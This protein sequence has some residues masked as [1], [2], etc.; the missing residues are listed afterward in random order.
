MKLYWIQWAVTDQTYI[1][2]ESALKAI[3]T[4]DREE[5]TFSMEDKFSCKCVQDNVFLQSDSAP[6]GHKILL[7]ERGTQIIHLIKAIRHNLHI[8]LKEA[9]EIT[10]NLPQV[11]QFATATDCSCF[12]DYLQTTPQLSDVKWK[13][14]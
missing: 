12:M 2:A 7:I 4:L 9:K 5:E 6:T 11:L 3:E 8:G 14:V 10:E 1:V 13:R